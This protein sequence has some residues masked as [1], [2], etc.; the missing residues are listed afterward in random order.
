MKVLLFVFLLSSLV[1]LGLGSRHQRYPAKPEWNRVSA[2]PWMNI[3]SVVNVLDYGAKGDGVTDDTAA[4][5]RAL[6]AMGN[7]Q[8]GTVFAPRGLFVFQGTIIIPKAVALE[9]TY[10]AVPSHSG[11]RD[12]GG[13]LPN[14]GTIF[15]T[16]SG[17]GSATGTAFITLQ[18]DSTLRGVVIYYPEQVT[19]GVP[20]PFPY[21]VS[22]SGNNPAFYD[23]ELLNPYQGV[24]ASG[25]HRHYIARI[26][27]QPLLMGIFV[28]QTYD[29]GRIED[30]H[31]NPWFSMEA[32]LFAWQQQNGRAFVVAR[33]DWEYIFNTF[34]FGYKIGYHFIES[35]EGSCNGNFLGIGADN[36]YTSVQIDAADS[37]G[38]LITNGEFTA[39]QGPDPTEVVVGANNTG[40]VQFVNTA[41]WGPGHQIAKIYGTGTVGFIGCTFCQWNGD[42]TG[43][44]AVQAYGGSLI[45][46]GSEFQQNAP[47]VLLNGVARAVIVGN[48]ITGEI[49]INNQGTKNA[50]ISLNSNL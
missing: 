9:G 4:F 31:W 27:G 35:A 30:V 50:Q 40:K 25:A 7:A 6:N 21:A 10:L 38:I 42:N 19:K 41:F 26:Q 22:M 47:Q 5:Q 36:C 33:S 23:S 11:I 34:A 14:D 2:N 45:I 37:F 8:G 17:K 39:F 13:L 16:Y 18:E 1:G 46:E 44:Y 24:Y 32:T 3:T 20:I 49:Q 12:S 29:I 48:L 43:R 15:L 28:D